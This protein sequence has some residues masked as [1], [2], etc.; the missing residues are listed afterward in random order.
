M[1]FVCFFSFSLNENPALKGKSIS[2]IQVSVLDQ[3]KAL[4]IEEYLE[5][6]KVYGDRENLH[7]NGE[8]ALKRKM[9]ALRGFYA[10]YYRH[11][12]I[13]TNPSAAW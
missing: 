6:L 9:V 12:M 1:T 10:Y 4:D 3:I 5:Y 2:D 8:R 11:E 13:R 7:T